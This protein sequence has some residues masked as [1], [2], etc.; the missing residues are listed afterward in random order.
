MKKNENKENQ[1]K[2]KSRKMSIYLKILLPTTL[3]VILICLLLSLNTYI[4]IRNAM[5]S[6]AVEEANMAAASAV[7]VIDG[8]ILMKLEPGCE[9]GD[10]YQL[11]LQELTEMQETCGIKY[12]FTLYE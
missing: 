9:S 6:M 12:L 1:H 7:S 8:D 2:E 5:L 10:D 3:I 4:Q 11:L